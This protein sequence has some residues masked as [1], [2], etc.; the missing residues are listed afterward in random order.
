MPTCSCRAA[1]FKLAFPYLPGALC[2]G[3]SVLRPVSL[4]GPLHISPGPYP[5]DLATLGQ[6]VISFRGLPYVTVSGLGEK[7]RKPPS[8]PLSLPLPCC[9]LPPTPPPACVPS[10]PLCPQ[11]Q[12]LAASLSSLLNSTGCSLRAGDT[13]HA[14]LCLFPFP[15]PYLA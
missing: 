12:E 11:P 2:L 10:C 9:C 7:K 15:L 6:D 14:I 8:C 5:T 13:P 4:R 1:P 3:L